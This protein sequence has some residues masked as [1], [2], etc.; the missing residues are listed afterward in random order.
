MSALTDHEINWAFTLPDERLAALPLVSMSQWP[1]AGPEEYECGCVTVHR[2]SERDGRN[3]ER[4]FE[5][6][7]ARPCRSDGCE[8][9]TGQQ[10]YSDEEFA[11]WCESLKPCKYCGEK[12]YGP[13]CECERERQP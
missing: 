1:Q 12:F 5:M 3:G 11:K 13:V 8:L 9:G 6:R 4:P 2:I 7:L 10:R